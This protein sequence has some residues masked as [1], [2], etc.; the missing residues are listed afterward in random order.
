MIKIKVF[1]GEVYRID[2]GNVSMGVR[3]Y[4]YCVFLFGILIHSVMVQELSYD[5]AIIIFGNKI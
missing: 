3:N 5:E 4:T 1:P 2:R